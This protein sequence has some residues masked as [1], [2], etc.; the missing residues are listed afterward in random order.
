MPVVG[1]PYYS[2]LVTCKKPQTKT[3]ATRLFKKV[4]IRF[5]RYHGHLDHTQ[6]RSALKVKRNGF[7]RMED[8]P[9]SL[10][11]LTGAISDEESN[12]EDESYNSSLGSNESYG[13]GNEEDSSDENPHPDEEARKSHHETET[14]QERRQRRQKGQGGCQ[15]SPEERVSL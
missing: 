5:L 6:V 2:V 10:A 11:H 8:A 14:E 9:N 3:P 7:G 13:D 12:S 15:D 4:Y 1:L